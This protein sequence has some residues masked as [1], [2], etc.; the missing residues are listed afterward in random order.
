VERTLKRLEKRGQIFK[1]KAMVERGE[2]SGKKYLVNADVWVIAKKRPSGVFVQRQRT[3]NAFD[4]L[5]S[6]FRREKV[7]RLSDEKNDALAYFTITFLNL[8][9]REPLVNSLRGAGQIEAL[10]EFYVPAL[11]IADNISELRSYLLMKFQSLTRKDPN[12][13]RKIKRILKEY[14]E[15]Y[16]KEIVAI[17]DAGKVF[18]FIELVTGYFD[19]KVNKDF[20]R[21]KGAFSEPEYNEMIKH[22]ESMMDE[23]RS[24]ISEVNK[25]WTAFRDDLEKQAKSLM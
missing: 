5:L 10:S 12:R 13:S 17:D 11:K 22:I 4:L 21:F 25:L 20:K 16:N 1:E 7:K 19:V 6:M 24:L 3:S 18:F 14:D 8:P 15:S 2:V 9:S 23:T